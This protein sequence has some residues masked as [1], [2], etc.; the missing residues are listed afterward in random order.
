MG[1]A[2]ANAA[3]YA[4]STYNNA[5]FSIHDSGMIA[6]ADDYWIISVVMFSAF[7]GSLGFPVVLIMGVL[8]NRPR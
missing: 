7:V 5:G 6:F 4:I 8:W 2:A 1:D 3:F